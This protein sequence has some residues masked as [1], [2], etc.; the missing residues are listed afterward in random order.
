MEIKI[1][2]GKDGGNERKGEE[3]NERREMKRKGKGRINIINLKH[4]ISYTNEY[5]R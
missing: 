2:R 4:M 3:Y 1:R 5:N